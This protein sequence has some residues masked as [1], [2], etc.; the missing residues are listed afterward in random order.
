MKKP[1]DPVWLEI[2]ACV[3]VDLETTEALVNELKRLKN[4]ELNRGGWFLP[5][6]WADLSKEEC[7]NIL[8][9]H[10]SDPFSLLV[11]V[12]DRLKEKNT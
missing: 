1:F 6:K 5:K 8:V 4:E 7:W 10:R 11:A 12:Q 3:P 2:G 9:K